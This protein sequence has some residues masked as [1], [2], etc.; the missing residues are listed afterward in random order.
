MAEAYGGPVLGKQWLGLID[1]VKVA[2]S[3]RGMTVEARR[4]CEKDRKKRNGVL[5]VQMIVFHAVIF[6]LV[7]PPLPRS[8]GLSPG[9]RWDAVT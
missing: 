6:C 3:N 8:G 9:D 1:G 5:L 4:Q 2:L 7:G